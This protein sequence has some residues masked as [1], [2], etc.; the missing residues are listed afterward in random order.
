MCYAVYIATNQKLEEK[1]FDSKKEDIRISKIDETIKTV[2]GSKFSKKN[3]YYLG[4][5]GNSCSCGFAFASQ[6]IFLPEEAEENKKAPI[7]LIKLLKELTLIENVEYYCC[8]EGDQKKDVKFHRAINIQTI[9]MDN[10]F[11]LVEQEFIDFIRTFK[12]KIRENLILILEREE[13]GA[14]LKA[15]KSLKK[16]AKTTL[17]DARKYVE[18]LAIELKKVK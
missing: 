17:I 1:Y 4:S 12:P 16:Q 13:K 6:D 8:W 2:L 10:Y 18:Y 14:V 15:I 3:I 9:T 7:K 11:G 5:D